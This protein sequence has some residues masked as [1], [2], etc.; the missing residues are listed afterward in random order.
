MI[1]KPMIASRTSD[2]ILSAFELIL[3]IVL[4]AAF[5]GLFICTGIGGQRSSAAIFSVLYPIVDDSNPVEG[6]S[7]VW[8]RPIGANLINLIEPAARG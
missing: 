4:I 1:Q 7:L 3:M 6:V 2:P 8:F 5:S